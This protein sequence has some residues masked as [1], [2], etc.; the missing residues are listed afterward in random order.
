MSS[1]FPQLR[2]G[3]RILRKD[4]GFTVT[5][6]LIL[7][8]GIGAN[9]AIF[10]VVNALLLRS[11]P[12]Q[13]PDRLVY[14]SA[15][16]PTRHVSGGGI[17]V[18]QYETL[19][20]GNRS[21][22][23]ITA[24]VSDGFALTGAGE[25]ESL[26]AARVSPNFF[27][28]LG[29][30]LALGRGFRP[31]EG[32][33]GSRPLVVISHALWS[34]HFSSDP[35]IV[36]KP[37][38]LGH[39]VYTIIGVAP[40]EFPFPFPAID[41]WV[42][43]IMKYGGLQPEQIRA[44][45]GMLNAFARLRPGMTA[46]QAEAEAAV[47]ARQ[48]R[49]GH[50]NAPDADPR[51]KLEVVDMHESFVTGIRATLLILM[52]AVGM[53]LLIACANV[54]SL[55]LARATGRAREIAIRAAMGASRGSLVRQ[56][57]LESL[58]LSA[59]GAA[60]GILIAHFGVAWL[61]KVDAGNN[62]PGFQP[63]R[64]DP[65]VLGFTLLVS[66]FSAILFGLVP[67]LQ[68][69]RPDLNSV[70]RDS[71]WGTTAGAHRHRTRSLLVAAQM[72]LSIVLLIGAALLLESFRNLQHVNPGFDPQ[73][74][75]TMN[76]NLP[77]A[78]YPDNG[79]RGRFFR[80]LVQR[81]SSQPGVVSANAS[82]S[83]PMGLF[84]LSPIL[85]EGQP[86]VPIGQ[87][88]L[89]VWN[90]VTPGYFRTFGIPVLR[91]RDFTWS[92]DENSPRV[93]IVSQSLAD[94]FW[95][96][97]NP[98]G[99]HLTF[100]RLQTPFEIVGV[101]GNTRN[102]GL[103]SDPGVVMFTPYPQWTIPTLSVNIRTVGDPHRLARVATAQVQSLDRDLPV[104][105]LR[106]AVELL[107]IQLAQS[108]EILYLIG[109]FAGIALL[110]AVTGLYG[111]MAYSVAQRTTEIGIRQA[112]GANRGDILRLV[113]LQAIRLAIFGTAAGG[114]AAFFATRLL[115]TLLFQVKAT[116]PAAFGGISLLFLAVALAASAIPA[117]Q[118]TRVD[119][120]KALR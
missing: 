23:G 55:T 22:T 82:F 108:R 13:D 49:Q 91:G 56:L 89:A 77:P 29:A 50:P 81:L 44:G 11:L 72:A 59:A 17:S 104:T 116:D 20:D 58:L 37:V 66:A 32:G 14:V 119:P 114:L 112:I 5:A 36:G 48:Y 26:A 113:V 9:T 3:I 85:A 115:S 111:S 69:S 110:L 65:G 95:P 41:V 80:D 25:P 102:N 74:V 43:R 34:R 24:F 40:P 28:V 62:L 19:R 101:A 51:R 15:F 64:L 2:F 18:A 35:A 52:G 99:K 76:V 73:G 47:L 100:T 92:D 84:V 88:P 6:V 118:A 57:V 83:R 93:V 30:R 106:T 94:R 63:I 78:K 96:H 75:L 68:L 71:G 4:P 21:F 90:G 54:A 117:W 98:L 60:L 39:E 103:Q 107:D 12:L 86:L 38:T 27:E 105:G 31:D 120:M 33:E 42:S 79:S 1:D 67:A 16:D 87:R 53:V 8:L 45:A 46:G 70:L 7:A 97:E 10:S 109:G 61:V